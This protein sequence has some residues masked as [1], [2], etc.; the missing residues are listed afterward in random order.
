MLEINED[1]THVRQE[2]LLGELGIIWCETNHVRGLDVTVSES[3][4]VHFAQLLLD[5]EQEPHHRGRIAA[6]VSEL[7]MIKRAVACWMQQHTALFVIVACSDSACRYEPQASGETPHFLPVG[8][9]DS[10]VATFDSS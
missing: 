7:G 10:C 6:P 4:R 5:L 8:D 9:S 3:S 1:R 2:L